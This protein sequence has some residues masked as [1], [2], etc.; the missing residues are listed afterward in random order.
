MSGVYM[1]AIG[2]LW[3]PTGS[4]PRW[5]AIITFVLAVGF[6]F[7]SDQIRKFSLHFSRVG[8]RS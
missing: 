4:M 3:G 5:L 7:G 2:A 1:T 8:V 6:L